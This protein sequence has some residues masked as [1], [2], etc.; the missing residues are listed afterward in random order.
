MSSCEHYICVTFVTK[1][2]T[3]NLANGVVFVTPNLYNGV[4]Q[5][6]NGSPR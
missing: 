6:D 3:E 1:V 2:V 5:G 4:C